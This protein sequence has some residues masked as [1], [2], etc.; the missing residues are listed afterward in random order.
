MI[1]G[2]IAEQIKKQVT[3]KYI[4]WS[5]DIPFAI[6]SQGN[7]QTQYDF[8]QFDFQVSAKHIPTEDFAI[9]GFSEDFFVKYKM[10]KY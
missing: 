6:V 4:S 1:M 9:Q 10:K 8:L 2:N 7:E 5:N 3:E